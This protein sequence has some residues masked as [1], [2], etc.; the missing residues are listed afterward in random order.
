MMKRLILTAFWTSLLLVGCSKSPA[1]KGPE[2]FDRYIFFSQQVESKAALIED[3]EILKG[4]SLGVV[5]YKYANNS[6]WETFKGTSGCQPNVFLGDDRQVVA[7]EELECGEGGSASYAP[8]QGW[9]NTKKYAFFACYPFP[10]GGTSVVPAELSSSVVPAIQYTLNTTSDEAFKNSMLDVMVAE[11]L[12]DKETS[13]DP[14]TFIFRHCLSCLGIKVKNTAARNVVVNNVTLQV[15]GIQFHTIKIPLDGSEIATD[16]PSPAANR[17]FPINIPGGNLTLE[18]AKNTLMYTELDDKL[19]FIP[20]ETPVSIVLSVSYT[21]VAV[22]G[23]AAFEDTF[24]VSDIT[25]AFQKGMKHMLSLNFT[26]TTVEVEVLD[27]GWN[28]LDSVD[29]TFN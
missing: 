29:S 20:Q 14:L 8:L 27:T 22:D 11:P 12:L 3:E 1:P 26:E 4:S 25:T 24:K 2:T 28:D 17:A 19:I 18:P 21:R 10:K 13:S 9:S 7:F 15:N 23:H 5:G 6:N 16:G